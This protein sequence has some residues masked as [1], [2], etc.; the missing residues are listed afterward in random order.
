VH[1]TAAKVRRRV[2]PEPLGLDQGPLTKGTNVIASDFL[3]PGQRVTLTEPEPDAKGKLQQETA[4]FLA[5]AERCIE[6][7]SIQ[8]AMI[9]MYSGID[10]MAWLTR[11]PG[12]DDVRPSDFTDWVESFL[13]P[14]SGFPCAADDLYA[15]RCGLLQQQHTRIEKA[16]PR[17]SV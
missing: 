5:S 4:Q 10:A 3:R 8:S 7:N 17:E 9:L 15:A 2:T 14:N 16:S 13:L 1:P 12:V 6:F 11:P